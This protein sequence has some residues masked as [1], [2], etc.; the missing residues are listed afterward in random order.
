MVA[1]NP[2]PGLVTEE[3]MS[4]L[5][6]RLLLVRTVDLFFNDLTHC[7]TSCLSVRDVICSHL[8]LLS[9]PPPQYFVL[10]LCIFLLEVLAGVLAYVYYQQVISYN[11]K[12]CGCFC[13]ALKWFC[14]HP[15]MT[16]PVGCEV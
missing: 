16:A 6:K 15:Y 4:G 3:R 2:Q 14:V 9:P 10:L 11:N 13:G 7:L 12:S 8:P 1:V 5:Q